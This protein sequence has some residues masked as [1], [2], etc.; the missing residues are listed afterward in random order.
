MPMPRCPARRGVI[1]VSAA[2]LIACASGFAPPSLLWSVPP[3]YGLHTP[4]RRFNSRVALLRV[5]ASLGEAPPP[6]GGAGDAVRSLS[7]KLRKAA[8][9]VAV[10]RVADTVTLVSNLMDKGEQKQAV[11]TLVSASLQGAITVEDMASLWRRTGL[12]A[13]AI[14]EFF[15]EAAIRVQPESPESSAHSSAPDSG[16]AVL[17]TRQAQR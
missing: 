10:S 9:K 17:Y 8:S 14:A 13:G 2:W 7:R 5:S 15:V 3:P 11:E 1:M 4:P 12:S 16:S 6:G